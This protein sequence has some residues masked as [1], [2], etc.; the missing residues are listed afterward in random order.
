LKEHL[1]ADI[2][3]RGVLT[4]Q[5]RELVTVSALFSLG[6]VDSQLQ[7][8][9][10][11]AMYNGDTA[12]QLT[13]LVSIIYSV[14]G[15][16]EGNDANEKLQTFLNRNQNNTVSEKGIPGK[17]ISA[18]QNK[19]DCTIFPKGEKITNDNFVGNA[20]LQQLIKS[21]S[22]NFTQV[23][24]VTFEPLARTKWHLHPAGQILLITSGTGYYQE[25]GVLKRI[26][27]KGDTIKC[28]SNVPHWHG[29]SKDDELI[30]IAITNTT[31]GA[32]VWLGTVTDEEYNK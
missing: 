22:L 19:E 2:F 24:T 17:N 8:H 15:L 16:K 7:G 28:P 29:A 14:V 21:D 1:F 32:V 10:S 5:E 23:G 9:L 6:G 26:I 25:K 18:R 12:A 30:Q 31:K 20:W 3:S 13:G 11:V 4:Y 27:K